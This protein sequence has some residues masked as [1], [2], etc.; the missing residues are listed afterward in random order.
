MM[1]MLKKE[2]KEILATYR[3]LLLPCIFLLLGLGQPVSFKFMPE[4]LKSAKLPEGTVLQIPMPSPA[5]VV[6]SILG[7]FNQIGVLMIILV[8][9]GTVAQEKASGISAGVLVKPLGKGSYLFAK[10][11]A[12]LGL[13]AAAFALGMA[14]GAFYTQLLIG[15][16]NWYAVMLGSLAYLPYLILAVALTIFTS[17]LF[18]TQVAAGGTALLGMLAFSLLP[19][20]AEWSAKLFPSA[21]TE[22]AGKVI[23][24]K[25]PPQIWHPISFSI[26]LI[27]LFMVL[28]WLSLK[29]QEL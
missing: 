21:L 2:C 6:S 17:T 13:T 19:K 1:A 14:A 26:G 11:I 23:A 10:F 16:V 18:S 7:Q 9:M 4:I 15:D 24:G 28:A 12:Y 8:V 20:L 29:R 5:E 25:T 27:A 22:Q 3:W